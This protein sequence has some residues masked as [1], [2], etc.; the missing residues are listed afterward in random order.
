VRFLARV[1]P[2]CFPNL[3]KY[4]VSSFRFTHGRLSHVRMGYALFS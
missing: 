4:F 1:S 2:P 3:A